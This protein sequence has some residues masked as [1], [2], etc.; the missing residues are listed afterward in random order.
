MVRL[1]GL[2]LDSVCQVRHRRALPWRPWRRQ[3]GCDRGLD[4]RER[5]VLEPDQSPRRLDVGVDQAVLAGPIFQ[6]AE[7]ALLG[8]APDPGQV[9]AVN[10]LVAGG[11]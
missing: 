3:R 8:Q 6:D 1:R 2:R 5:S 11:R 7:P 4:I 10:I 9:V